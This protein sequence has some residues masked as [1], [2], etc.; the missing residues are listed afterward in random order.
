MP[1]LLAKICRILA[2]QAGSCLY[3]TVAVK[4]ASHFG[5]AYEAAAAEACSR[6]DGICRALTPP[7]LPLPSPFFAFWGVPEWN[8]QVHPFHSLA[9]SL[10]AGS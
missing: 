7:F 9:V 4:A 8:T 10:D 5:T 1:K 2:F 6:L 3:V